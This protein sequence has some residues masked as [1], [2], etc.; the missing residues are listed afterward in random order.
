M[1]QEVQGVLQDE[2]SG[3]LA[4]QLVFSQSGEDQLGV[5]LKNNSD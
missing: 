1:Q 5:D 4:V 3:D 2:L